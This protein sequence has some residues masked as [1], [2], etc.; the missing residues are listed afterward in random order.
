MTTTNTHF[1]L[2]SS[3]AEVPVLHVALQDACGKAG[4]D[5]AAAYQLSTAVVE[6]VNNCIKHAYAEE[7]GHPIS[8]LCLYGREEFAV[9]IRDQG[10]PWLAF[11][12]PPR[13]KG[14]D[15]IGQ[16]GWVLI[17]A[18]TDS[19][20]YVREASTNVLTLRRRLDTSEKAVDADRRDEPCGSTEPVGNSLLPSTGPQDLRG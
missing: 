17:R 11:P 12:P 2:T 15:E 6:A 13:V 1:R 16:F 18:Y 14:L 20:T 8:L 5:E 7:P 4:L 10:R 3:P 9:E 19:Q